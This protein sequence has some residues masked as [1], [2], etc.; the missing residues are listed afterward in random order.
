MRGLPQAAMRG[1]PQAAGFVSGQEQSALIGVFP[2]V[3][4]GSPWIIE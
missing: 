4:R 2:P 3:V 1:L